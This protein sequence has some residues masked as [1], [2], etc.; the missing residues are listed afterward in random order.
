MSSAF[1]FVCV[2]F[3]PGAM[4]SSGVIM[5]YEVSCCWGGRTDWSV[6]PCL[7]IQLYWNIVSPMCVCPWGI[8]EVCTAVY[9]THW[10]FRSSPHTAYVLQWTQTLYPFKS[11]HTGGQQLRVL[12]RRMKPINKDRLLLKKPQKRLSVHPTP[13]SQN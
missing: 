9:C 2:Y 12:W 10:G 13:I 8:S 4:L 11:S 1:V 6:C 5:H 7:Q 3:R